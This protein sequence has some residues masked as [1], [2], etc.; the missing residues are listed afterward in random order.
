MRAGSLALASALLNIRDAFSPPF[1]PGCSLPDR[2]GHPGPPAAGRPVLGPGGAGAGDSA[3]GGAATTAAVVGR[4]WH[5]FSS[6]SDLL[7][8]GELGQQRYHPLFPCV[9]MEAG[10]LAAGAAVGG[11]AALDPGAALSHGRVAWL[12]RHGIRP[13]RRAAGPGMAGAGLGRLVGPVYLLQSPAAGVSAE[14]PQSSGAGLPAAAA[15]VFAE[16][17]S[18][19]APQD[20]SGS[21]GAA[22][23]PQP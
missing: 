14:R 12:D 7:H 1:P 4:C 2:P 16:C 21:G 17:P 6:N 20:W 18:S 8:P 19:Q 22:V 13:G 10:P 23:G 11:A 3:G 9:A 15:P 5:V